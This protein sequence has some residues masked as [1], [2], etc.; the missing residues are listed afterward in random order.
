MNK[1]AIKVVIRMFF[2]FTKTSFCILT[3]L[4]KRFARGF[5]FKIGRVN[6]G[7]GITT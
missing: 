1:K 3:I 2:I 4:N 6:Y 7:Y 5:F